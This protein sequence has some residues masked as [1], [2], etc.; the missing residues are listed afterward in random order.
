MLDATRRIRGEW[1]ELAWGNFDV[2]QS[3]ETG[4]VHNLR[5]WVNLIVGDGDLLQSN[6]I[7]NRKPI[8]RHPKMSHGLSL[9]SSARSTI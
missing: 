9:H 4:R 7:N 2:A 6:R 8:G 1:P 5:I 3:P